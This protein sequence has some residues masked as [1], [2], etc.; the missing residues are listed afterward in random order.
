MTPP[1]ELIDR[2]LS[3]Y[4]AET[5]MRTLKQGGY[6]ISIHRLHLRLSQLISQ[7]KRKPIAQSE[8]DTHGGFTY[9]IPRGSSLEGSE[10]L[11]RACLSLYRRRAAEVGVSVQ[12]AM[13]FMLNAP[14]RLRV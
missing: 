5:A 7:G 14:E 4:S 6:D 2:L 12:D 11:L 3:E 9:E 1:Y 8:R 10:K 13:L